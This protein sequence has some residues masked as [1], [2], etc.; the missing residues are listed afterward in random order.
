MAKKIIDIITECDVLHVVGDV[1]QE[2]VGVCL[3]SRKV[4][5]GGMYIALRG[6]QVDGHQ[7]IASAIKNGARAIMCEQMPDE[8]SSTVCYLVVKDTARVAGIVAANYYDN[9]SKGMEVVGV[10]GTN[11]KTTVATLMY[12]MLCAMNYKVGLISTVCYKVG[13][14]VFDSTHTT[15]DAV[16]LQS[17]FKQMHDAGCSHVV[18][19]V[20]SHAIDQG[21]IVGVDFDYGVFTNLSRDH[22]DYHETFKDYINVKKKFFDTLKNDAVA[23]ANIDDKNGSVM[24]QNTK[25]KRVTYG[26]RRMADVKGRLLSND[27]AG[28]VM[29]IDDKQVMCQLRGEFNAY[30]ILAV[31]VV[32]MEIGLDEE[33]VLV[34]LSG[35]TGAPGR[36]EI[37][38]R[39]AS[40]QLGIVDYAHTPDA[41]ENV[42]RT[43]LELKEKDQ[44]VITVVGCGG[45][46]D[47]GKRPLMAQIAVRYSDKVILTSDNPRSEDPE[48]ILDEMMDGLTQDEQRQVMR[49]RD[50]KEAI[51]IATSIARED[52]IL[53]AGKGHEKYQDI[54]GVKT[55]FD[56]KKI[57]SELLSQSI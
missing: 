38:A 13:D 12:E 3:D 46:R 28:L 42:L 5:S 47:R 27:I 35:L 36:F 41:L 30:N 23:I 19:E 1:E 32:A 24:L 11:G 54:N 4:A 34:A 50:R 25:A 10:T 33:D 55:P 45:D 14:E 37:V 31:Y 18:M 44:E 22:L 17:L 40:K 8:V 57:L 2:I 9:P 43:I 6:T 15:P 16:R 49:V 21:R 52:I 7:Y 48:V 39:P 29:L 56:D 51:K 53:I 20:S 26:L